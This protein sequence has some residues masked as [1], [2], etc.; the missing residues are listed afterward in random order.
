MLSAKAS[1][2]PKQILASCSCGQRRFWEVP[3][4]VHT[5]TSRQASSHRTPEQHGNDPAERVALSLSCSSSPALLSTTF[6]GPVVAFDSTCT[7]NDPASS[8]ASQNLA[9]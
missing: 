5:G 6:R 2:S 1:C 9:K 3:L 4:L 8:Q 7:N